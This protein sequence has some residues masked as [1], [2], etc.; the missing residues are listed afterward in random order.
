MMPQKRRSGLQFYLERYAAGKRP[1][2][3]DPFPE[4]QPERIKMVKRRLRPR[5][6]SERTFQR[7]HE[8]LVPIVQLGRK[9]RRQHRAPR[10]APAPRVVV[11]PAPAPR[12]QRRTQVQNLREGGGVIRSRRSRRNL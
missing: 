9:W 1:F 8:D 11:V 5:C 2:C 10:R 3:V 4:Y 12:R 6:I 7:R